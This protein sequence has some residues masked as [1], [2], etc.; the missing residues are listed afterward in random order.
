[1]EGRHGES[2]L[3]NAAVAFLFQ[4]RQR[5]RNFAVHYGCLQRRQQ[6]RL[7]GLSNT[8]A[9]FAG[10]MLSPKFSLKKKDLEEVINLSRLKST[11]KNRVRDAMRKQPVPDP[12]EHLDFH[13]RW[14]LCATQSMLK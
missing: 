8:A 11:W 3:N 2:L 1:V 9:Y 13:T 10:K 6:L 12:L 7:N 14:T 4:Q 5:T